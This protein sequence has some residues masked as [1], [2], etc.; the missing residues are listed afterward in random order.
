[1]RLTTDEAAPPIAAERTTATPD[2]ATPTT[3]HLSAATSSSL[4]RRCVCAHWA[5]FSLLW[6][7]DDRCF[8]MARGVLW[9]F[10]V[11]SKSTY[12]V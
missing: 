2:A 11:S 6:R 8:M 9:E 7:I 3:N 12:R 1:M 5:L 4:V 10:V